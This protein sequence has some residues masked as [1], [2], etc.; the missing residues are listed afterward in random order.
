MLVG[1]RRGRRPTIVAASGHSQS[2]GEEA[3]DAHRLE[4]KAV[5]SNHYRIRPQLVEEGGTSGWKNRERERSRGV[6]KKKRI[7]RSFGAGKRREKK[8]FFLSSLM[9]TQILHMSQV[10]YLASMMGW[11]NKDYHRYFAT[12]DGPKFAPDK[13]RPMSSANSN[14]SHVTKY[15]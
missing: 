12:C 2:K 15:L 6:R 14:P 9:G 7:R 10:R 4:G 8:R 13:G 11:N 3:P 5:S 1:R